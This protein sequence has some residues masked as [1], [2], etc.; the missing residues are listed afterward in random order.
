MNYQELYKKNGYLYKFRAIDTLKTEQLLND[1]K[2]NYRYHIKP[3]FL[4]KQELFFKVHLLFKSFNEIIRERKILDI[5]EQIIGKNIVCWNSMLFYKKKA[6]FVTFHQ[7]LK[8]WKFLN[9]DCLTVSLAL[10]KSTTKNGCLVVIPESHKK[11]EEHK[12][13]YSPN[14]LL[15]NYQSVNVDK[16]EKKFFELEPGEF[17]V[18]HGNIL[19][20][21]YENKTN[22]DRVLLAIRYAHE[23]NISKIYNSATYISNKKNLFIKEPECNQNFDRKCL[24]F[25]ENLL[26]VQYKFYF[27]KKFKFLSKIGFAKIASI[28]VLRIIYNY[29]LK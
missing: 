28:K 5:V 19:H 16:R 1:F 14:N 21:S 26:R 2:E 23:K 22:D 9:E 24:N 6:K 17:T 8:Y 7:D 13:I 11:A 27:E 10:T 3:Q 20:G 29:F 15:A 25:R 12:K 4:I 18:H